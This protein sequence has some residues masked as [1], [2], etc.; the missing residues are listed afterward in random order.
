MCNLV[1]LALKEIYNQ[2][3]L[4]SA[5]LSRYHLAGVDYTLLGPRKTK[6]RTQSTLT[7]PAP[8]NPLDTQEGVGFSDILVASPLKLP[9]TTVMKY[10]TGRHMTGEKLAPELGLSLTSG[11]P[12]V[13]L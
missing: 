12:S 2:P 3:S 6:V 1:V 13:P 9:V 10:K 8:P 5:R 7:S 11:P 4:L